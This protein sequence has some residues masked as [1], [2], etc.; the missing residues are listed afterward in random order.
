MC[1]CGKKQVVSTEEAA[2]AAQRRADES[3]ETRVSEWDAA[4]DSIRKAT[5]NASS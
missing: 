3:R 2:A 5:A 4:V 1:G